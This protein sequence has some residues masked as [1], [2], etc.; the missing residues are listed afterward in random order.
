MYLDLLQNINN[1]LYKILGASDIVIELQVYINQK[2]NT[3][4]N[5]DSKEIILYEDDKPFVQ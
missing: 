4:N 2:R 3:N 1:I 5:I